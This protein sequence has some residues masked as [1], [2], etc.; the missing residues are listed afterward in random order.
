MSNTAG[1]QFHPLPLGGDRTSRR[2]ILSGLRPTQAVPSVERRALQGALVSRPWGRSGSHGASVLADAGPQEHWAPVFSSARRAGD[3]VLPAAALLPAACC[4]SLGNL[5]PVPEL[6][7][8]F[9]LPGSGTGLVPPGS[10]QSPGQ[11]EKRENGCHRGPPTPGLWL[12]RPASSTKPARTH[13]VA[14]HP[15]QNWETPEL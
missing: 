12:G 6:V 5:L 13:W 4:V 11:T 9:L 7:L 8:R 1:L 10:V 14:P 2:D 3:K 15:A